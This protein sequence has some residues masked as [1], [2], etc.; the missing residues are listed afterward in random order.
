MRKIEITWTTLA[1]TG[2]PYHGTARIYTGSG[3]D[4]TEVS[5]IGIRRDEDAFVTLPASGQAFQPDTVLDTDR[6]ELS[7][8]ADEY[9]NGTNTSG[10]MWRIVQD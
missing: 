6:T 7:E 2:T 8:M 1:G 5:S 4:Y 9:Y 3:I 10:V